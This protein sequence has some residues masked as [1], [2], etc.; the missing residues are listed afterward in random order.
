MKAIENII[1][2]FKF[3]ILDNVRLILYNLN[4]GVYQMNKTIS[5]Q[6]MYEMDYNIKVC[7]AVK[8]DWKDCRTFSC[9]GKPKTKN[10]FVYLN[11]CSAEYKLKD[12]R[13]MHACS[14]DVVY[15]PIGLE[16]SVEFFVN[17][18]DSFTIG[19]NAMFTDKK[20]E[21]FVPEG[22]IAIIGTRPEDCTVTLFS[23]I[24]DLFMSSPVFYSRIKS[25]F[26][27]ILS[28]LLKKM[29]HE[30]H[31]GKRYDVIKDGILLIENGCFEKIS[32]A[33]IAKKCNVSEI[34]FRKLFKEYSGKSPAGY[35]IDSKISRAKKYL[36][37]E[38]IGIENIAEL[39][40]FESGSYFS[41]LFKK[42]TG[43]TPIKYRN[44]F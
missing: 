21:S 14:G 15:T 23:D 38:N 18:R 41:R 13:V 36:R 9:M 42:K 44:S 29:R 4:N 7:D 2:F 32:I 8:Q 6:K 12:G 1:H 35:I 40:G 37:Y 3:S 17:E 30:K 33:D 28:V 22:D 34:Y 11:N 16:Y 20:G 27:E 5:F 19:I 31:I 24:N 10:I 39:C 43:M 25:V 26:Y